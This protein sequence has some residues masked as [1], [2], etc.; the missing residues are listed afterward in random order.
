VKPTTLVDDAEHVAHDL[1]AAREQEARRHYP[2]L[3]DVALLTL[4]RALLAEGAGY[5]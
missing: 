2:E 4:V 1:G 5:G 3:D